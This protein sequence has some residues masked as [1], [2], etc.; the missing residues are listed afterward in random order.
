MAENELAPPLLG[1]AWDGTG[2][3]LDGTIWGGE[4]FRVTDNDVERV[5]HLR[6]FRLPGGDAAVKEPRRVAL[7]LFH[8]LFSDHRFCPHHC[9]PLEAF[10]AAELTVLTTMLARGLNS[11]SCGSVGRLFDAVASFTGLCQRMR[12][13]GQAAMA[14][15]FALGGVVMDEAYEWAI[16]HQPTGIQLDWAPM[17]QAILAEVGQNVPVATISAR[18][19]NALAEAI[20]A[21]AKQVGEPRV[22]LSGGCFQNRYLTERSV[23][24]LR[25][26]GFQ[27]YWHQRVPP[28]D[29]GISLGQ[30]VAAHRE[31]SRRSAAFTPLHQPTDK[32]LSVPNDS[33]PITLK[34]AEARAP[35]PLI[36]HHASP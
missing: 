14:M 16:S 13:E 26:E 24:R 9:K 22:A 36:T 33:A 11:P 6:P 20:V 8:E 5:A 19:H 2:Y 12:F 34:R 28:N 21:V 29:G 15:E 32:L 17:I 30:V 25:A 31:F 4:F 1:V 7:G 35:S 10:S 27:P 3:G 23:K 18:F